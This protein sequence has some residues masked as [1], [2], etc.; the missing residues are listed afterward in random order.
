MRS[1]RSL[2]PSSRGI[3]RRGRQWPSIPTSVTIHSTLRCSLFNSSRLERVVRHF[4]PLIG[5]N[6]RIYPHRKFCQLRARREGFICEYQGLARR[7]AASLPGPV[8]VLFMGNTSPLRT[9]RSN[10]AQ[11]SDTG[12]MA[13]RMCETLKIFCAQPPRPNEPPKESK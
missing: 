12:L 11:Q 4:L 6:G 3:A 10:A 1:G 8:L 9:G 7:R 2:M 13:C 5:R